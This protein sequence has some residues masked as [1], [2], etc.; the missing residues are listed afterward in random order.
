MIGVEKGL[1]QKR[2][3]IK[4]KEIGGEAPTAAVAVAA[5]APAAP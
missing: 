1:C 2:K 4:R 5:T 3:K